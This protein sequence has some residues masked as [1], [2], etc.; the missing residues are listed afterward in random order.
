MDFIK[1]YNLVSPQMKLTQKVDHFTVLKSFPSTNCCSQKFPLNKIEKI[2]QLDVRGSIR[3]DFIGWGRGMDW[4]E[5]VA[6]QNC[7]RALVKPKNQPGGAVL[8]PQCLKWSTINIVD[9]WAAQRSSNTGYS[10]PR[11]LH[12]PE[13]TISAF[14]ITVNSPLPQS[15]SSKQSK[16]RL[17]TNIIVQWCGYMLVLLV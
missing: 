3:D 13:P 17:E 6:V 11:H 2:G 10:Q 5:K 16:F 12:V 4:R 14:H 15:A 8:A 1:R 9:V 7:G